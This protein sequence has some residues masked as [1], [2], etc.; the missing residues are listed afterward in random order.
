M[1]QQSIDGPEGLINFRDLG[2]LDAGTTSVRP[3]VLCRSADLAMLTETGR[4]MLRDGGVALV[5]DLRSEREAAATFGSPAAHP[6]TVRLPLLDGELRSMTGVPTLSGLY[7][8]LLDSAG[9]AFARVAELVAE[10]ED[11]AVLVHCAAG[12]DRTGVAVALLLE[13]VGVDR[14]AIVADY[15]LSESQLSQEWA[16]AIVSSIRATGVEITPQV[17]ALI[18]RSPADEMEVTLE[19][20]DDRYGGAVRYLAKHGFDADALARLRQRLLAVA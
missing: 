18:T 12:K 13:A 8:D 17:E 19:H 9:H 7:A 14:Q 6:A 16:A 10:T 15:A 1:T 20:L 4:A 11:G 2:G 3:G 5:I